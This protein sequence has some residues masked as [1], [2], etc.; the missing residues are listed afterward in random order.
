MAIVRPMPF[1]ARL[2]AVMVGVL[3]AG[4]ARAGDTKCWFEHGAVVVPAAFADIAGDFILDLSAPHSQL[5]AT[6]ALA[7]G[8]LA[9]APRGDLA[10]A[11]VTI[12][13]FPMQVEDLDAR[14][15]PFVTGITGILG[16]DIARRFVIEIGFSP[17]R[18]MLSRRAGRP[19]SGATSLAI[20]WIG[21][22]PAVRASVCD[23]HRCE[24]G[25]FAIDT[26][27]QGVRLAGAELSRRPA[28]VDAASRS[29]PPARLRALSVGD[30]LFEQTPAGLMDPNPP[31]LVGTIG[32]AIWSQY[33]LILDARN[34][35][36]ELVP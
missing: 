12:G 21:D 10:L 18:V 30:Q 28:G 25:F 15:Q 7:H 22:V 2:V 4:A 11:G 31:G 16:A 1:A 3:A 35:R 5:H 8:I 33:H 20:R 34:G 24:S 13:D 32:D 29:D 36:L 19:P 17:C 26:A 27:S 9:A 6:A 23:N 14:A